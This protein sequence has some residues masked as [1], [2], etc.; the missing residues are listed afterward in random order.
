MRKSSG[1]LMAGAFLLASFA[2]AQ[3]SYTVTAGGPPSS[4][5]PAAVSAVLEPAATMFQGASPCEIWWRKG[6]PEGNSTGASGDTLYS[7][8]SMGEFVG[9]LHF[10]SAG[11]DY[12]GQTIKPG[13]YTMRYALIPQDGNHMGVSSYRD[14]L[15]LSPVSDDSNPDQNLSFDAVVKDS[16]LST[17]TG[18]PAVLML[19][20]PSQ[21]AKF[22]SATQDDQ[23]NWV[24]NVKL[25]AKTAT[26]ADAQLPFAVVLVGQYQG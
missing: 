25:N 1:F 2:S 16:R 13:Y 6:I 12:R 21:N 9:V 14:F 15:L 17:G 7:G 19:D 8:L 5:I 11:K 10:A 23:G 22:P 4:A 24:L 20:P 3:G 18:H 26:G